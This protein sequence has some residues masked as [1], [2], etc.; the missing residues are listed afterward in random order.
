[1]CLAYFSD[2]SSITRKGCCVYACEYIV[3]VM[4]LNECMQQSLLQI[5]CIPGLELSQ[6][7]FQ[8]YNPIGQ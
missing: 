2:G 8:S 7:T 5:L 4:Q 1:M 3:C 6:S